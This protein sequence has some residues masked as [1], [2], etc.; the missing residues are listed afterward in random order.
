VRR[1]MRRVLAALLV[2]LL[3]GLAG[4][5]T[6]ATTARPL[7][8]TSLA[9][10]F[11]QTGSE[12]LPDRWWVAFGDRALDRL[13]DRA[14]AGNLDLR[15]QW[16]RLA[17]AEAQARG[18][19]ASR[20]PTLDATAS[21]GGSVTVARDGTTTQRSASLGLAASYEIDLWGRVRAARDAAA[22]SAVATAHDVQ[23]AAM[24]LSAEVATTWYDLVEARAEAE[25]LAG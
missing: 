25:L 24:T 9:A 15:G 4:C 21:G 1:F 5:A 13:V 14:L 18:A 10:S 7:A 6:T 23:T 22:L 8:E 11:S 17:Q 20:W 19:E 2:F 12:R 3:L 16:Q